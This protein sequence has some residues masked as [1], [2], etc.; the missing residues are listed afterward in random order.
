MFAQN[1]SLVLL[2]DDDQDMLWA[3]RNILVGAGFDIAEAQAGEPGLEL[4][5]RQTPDA[6]VLDMRMS[7]IGGEEV[8]HRLL[9]RDRDLPVVIATAYGDIAGAISAIKGGAFEY[10]T[11]PFCNERLVDAV[12]RAVSWRRSLRAAPAANLRAAVTAAMGKSAAIQKLVDEMEAVV[13]SG[14]SVVIQGETVSGKEVVARSMHQ[15]GQ[16]AAKPFVVVDCGAVA[17]SLVNSEFFGHEKGAF[18]GAVGRQR[19]WFE[20]A[21][22]Q[23]TIFLDEI[24]NLVPSG[25]T[26]L[27]RTLEERVIHRVGSREPIKIDVRVLA[28]T[29]DDLKWRS[30][31]G[32]FREDLYFRLAEYV[33]TVPPLRSRTEDIAFLAG[34]FLA[35]ARECLGRPPV[36]IAPDA[37]DLLRE[38][39]WPGN[40]RE[41]RNVMRRVA[42][43]SSDMIAAAHVVDGIGGDMTPAKEPE[44]F[45]RA[46][47]SL[48]DQIRRQ[49]NAVERDAVFDALDRAKG[50]KAEAARLLG[51]DY[52]TYRMKLKKL[53]G[54]ARISADEQ[55]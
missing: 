1:R 17:E 4:A 34:R 25:Q 39:R 35:Q 41:L 3:M 51:V 46:T 21:A 48:R 50:N 27:L 24:G 31:S 54:G 26:A 9:K 32:A 10:L 40:V 45:E 30:K 22:N 5:A 18:T 8:L 12:R 15:H 7:G 52:K 55:V 28:A 49:V 29:N 14:Y 36:D 44:Q 13:F 20:A 53:K 2:I 19:G 47:T 37:L 33:I 42:L 16:R 23:G 6:V 43:V 11:K 38:Y